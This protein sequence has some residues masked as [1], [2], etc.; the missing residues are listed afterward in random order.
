M[1]TEFDLPV[2]RTRAFKR[3]IWHL[4]TLEFPPVVEPVL[5]VLPQEKIEKSLIPIP[6]EDAFSVCPSLLAKFSEIGRT[7]RT[8]RADP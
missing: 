2:P 1:T 4:K 3:K 5:P 7:A 8:G 6:V